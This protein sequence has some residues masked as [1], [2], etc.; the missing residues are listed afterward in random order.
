MPGWRSGGP[1]PV[2]AQRAD[3]R[4]RASTGAGRRWARRRPSTSCAAARRARRQGRRDG[5]RRHH[6]SMTNLDKVLIPGRDGESRASPSATSSAT[7]PRIAPWMTPYLA[8]RP[9]NLNRFPDGI[10]GAKGG[11]WHKAVPAHAPAWVRRWPNPL[12]DEGETREYLL[13]RRR[14]GARLGGELR[15]HRDP[16][17]D[18]DGAVAGGA[19]LRARRHRP[20]HRDDVGRDAHAGAASSASRSTTSDSSPGRRS[21]ASAASRSGS[22]SRR[23]YT[24]DDTS[25]VRRDAVA[26]RRRASCPSSS[27]GSGRRTSAAAWRGSTT[28][29]T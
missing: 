19:V 2:R 21:P 6:G 12:A 9:L 18:V 23:G 7:T 17:V 11:F 14:P 29:R 4:G 24:F 3:E 22:R 1:P 26:N 28:P 5:R 16:P 20:R 27:A 15:R 8:G 25:R 10:D 13:D